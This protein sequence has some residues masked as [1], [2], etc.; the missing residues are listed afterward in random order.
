MLLTTQG[1]EPERLEPSRQREAVLRTT[2]I[3]WGHDG[4]F[5]RPEAL[6][7]GAERSLAQILPARAGIRWSRAC[8]RDTSRRPM[9]PRRRREGEGGAKDA[10]S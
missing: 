5:K 4:R 8:E 3:P 10:N 6:P 7:A 2:I 1:R 9:R